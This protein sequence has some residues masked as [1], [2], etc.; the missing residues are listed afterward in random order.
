MKW[1]ATFITAFCLLAYSGVFAQ[2]KRTSVWYD[3]ITYANYLNQDWKALSRHGK[4]AIKHDFDY[5]Y[6]RMRM[7]TA[8]F[9]LRK[10]RAA[11]GH[12]DKASEFNSSDNSGK[13]MKYYSYLNLGDNEHAQ[14]LASS[15][16]PQM[17]KENDIRPPHFPQWL[18]LESGFSPDPG[19]G[20]YLMGTDSIYG[21]Q[22]LNRNLNYYHLGSKFMVKPNL[23]A[24]V[25]LTFMNIGKEKR[26]EFAT[27]GIHRD[28]VTAEAYG[29]AYYYSFPK[30]IN[31][32]AFHYNL[33]QN[34]LYF[35]LEYLPNEYWKVIPSLHLLQVRSRNFQSV[36]NVTT[37]SDTAWY[38]ILDNSWHLFDY[39]SDEY[40]FISSDTTFNNFVAALNISR[41]WQNFSFGIQGSISNFNKKKQSQLGG[42]IKWYPLGNSDLFVSFSAISLNSKKEK[43][44]VYEPA[45]G[46]RLLK[47]LWL[48]GFVTKGNLSLYNEGNGAMVYNQSDPVVFRT[49]ANAFVPV[50][51]HLEFF[52]SYRFLKKEYSST[53]ITAVENLQQET[54]LTTVSTTQN[55]K[56]HNFS[57]GIKWK[58]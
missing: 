28:S 39:N 40:S 53:H 22:D 15:F 54:V 23:F 52:G 51:N 14:L 25:G 34:D 44:M 10:Y 46:F 33:R 35:S 26:Y 49:G 12:Y 9:N 48:S 6:L 43:R 47:N 56:Q 32:T 42:S 5:Y 20:G 4:E 13:L 7:A 17:K 21:D 30:L 57:A 55:Y 1:T 27:T 24:Y 37:K 29:S 3:S 18:Y 2:V 58:L 19:Q 11:I 41:D 38:Q 36:Y 50:G 31:D 8:D 45:I 16:T